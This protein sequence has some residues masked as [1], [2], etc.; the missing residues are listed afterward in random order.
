MGTTLEYDMFVIELEK[1]KL[2]GE[3]DLTT[4][5]AEACQKL[6]HPVPS[7]EL[8]KVPLVLFKL[9]ISTS[10][11]AQS[12]GMVPPTICSSNQILGSYLFLTLHSEFMSSIAD[13]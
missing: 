4:E 1:L 12:Q 5:N 10:S 2:K 8:P 11:L 13:F 9:I 3:H 6:E 7:P